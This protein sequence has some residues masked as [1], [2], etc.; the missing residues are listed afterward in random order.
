MKEFKCRVAVEG[1]F[2]GPVFAPGQSKRLLEK[3]SSDSQGEIQRLREAERTL[4]KSIELN[5]A[6]VANTEIQAAVLT[7]LDDEAFWSRIEDSIEVHLLDASSAL[8]RAAEELSA[9]LEN[10]DSEYIR[11]RQEDIRG[12]TSKLISIIEG[13]DAEP[14]L[15]SAICAHE[16][17][18]AQLLTADEQLLGALLTVKGSPNSHTSILASNLGIPYL[19]GNEEVERAVAN[20]EFVIMDSA[21]ATVIVNPEQDI[22]EAA[23]RRMK[24]HNGHTRAPASSKAQGG[25]EVKILANIDGA[26][27]IPALLEADADGVGLFRTEYMFVRRDSIPTEEEQYEE[28]RAVL[29]AMGDREVIIRLADIGSDKD[30]ACMQLPKEVNP[31]L[32]IRGIRTLLELEELLRPQLRALL[33]VGVYENLKIMLP[34]I[35]SKWEIVEIKRR[36]H[37][38]AS[39]LEHENVEYRIPKL[40]IMIETPA[41]ALI[42]SELAGEVDFFSIGTN[43]LTQ[44]TLALDREACGLDRFFNPH[45]EAIYILIRMTVEAAHRQG[46][47]VG[48]CGQLAADTKAVRRL[49]ELGVDELSVGIGRVK[50]IR[51]VC[52]ELS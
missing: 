16:L 30:I 42:A 52:S 3:S 35:T 46:I 45:H 31:A 40:G 36:I 4:R 27:D 34:L 37:E 21:S 15:R 8:M 22:R 50:R 5:K 47:R 32:G 48:I 43:D 41:A 25:S 23:I 11:S 6:S 10:V 26:C 17:S 19:I 29:E 28:Y 12:V 1:Y 2:A 9:M 18:P 24:E 44:Y 13:A 33:R 51:K 49:L 14:Q 38:L 7:I 20:A 39:E